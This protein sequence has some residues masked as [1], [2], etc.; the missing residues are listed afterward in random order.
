MIT[1]KNYAAQA[2]RALLESLPYYAEMGYR[3]SH[4]MV[5]TVA[6]LIGKA[7]HFVTPDG[8]EILNDGLKG[9]HGMN[10]HLPYDIMTIEYFVDKSQ[11]TKTDERETIYISKRLILAVDSKVFNQYIDIKADG[12]FVFSCCW[13]DG[14]WALQPAGAILKRDWQSQNNYILVRALPEFLD[15]EFA[16]G[17]TTIDDMRFDVSSDCGALMELLEALSCRNV[18]TANHQDAVVG[19]AKRVKEGKLPFYQTK[20]LVINSGY[21]PSG[22]TGN[23]GGSHVSPRQH[24]RRGHIRRIESGNIW[25]N[26]CVVGD[27]NK[28]I[29][30]K[31]YSVV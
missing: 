13:L 23:G 2:E 17:R 10:I 4:K 3:G 22:K 12:I 14:M 8:G 19:N 7:V 1:A 11:S 30:K 26:S 16:L 9:L 18:S 6:E 24:L 28:G 5:K 27:S 20:M 25:V 31:Q 29:I 15:E 21:S